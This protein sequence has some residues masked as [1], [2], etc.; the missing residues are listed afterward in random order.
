LV[1]AAP[2]I[3]ADTFRELAESL[4]R[5]SGHITL[6]ASSKDK[7]IRASKKLHMNPRLGA[8]PLVVLPGVESIDASRLG[9]DWLSHSYFGDNWPLLSD[10]HALFSADLPASKRFGLEKHTDGEKTYYAKFV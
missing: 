10:I 2:D 8:L 3:D 1:L 9:S 6:Y 5:V 4:K 7:A